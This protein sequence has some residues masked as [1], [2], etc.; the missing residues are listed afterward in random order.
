MNG[1]LTWREDVS[2]ELT[3][4]YTLVDADGAP[5]ARLTAVR[6]AVEGGYVHVA[7]PGVND[8]QVLSAPAIRHLSYPRTA[9]ALS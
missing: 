1:R 5:A 4:G 6:I 2:V 7:V 8:I 3:P 9:P